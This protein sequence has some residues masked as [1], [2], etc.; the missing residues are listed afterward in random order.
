MT[1][2]KE[3]QIYDAQFWNA[4]GMANLRFATLGFVPV[5][6]EN[7]AAVAADA[8]VSMSRFISDTGLRG[9]VTSANSLS[10]ASGVAVGCALASGEI[11]S[12]GLSD[13]GTDN[14]SVSG[15]KG[16]RLASSESGSTVVTVGLFTGIS[17]KALLLRFIG[18]TGRLGN[19]AGAPAW[20]LPVTVVDK[21]AVSSTGDRF[22]SSG[23]AMD[24]PGDATTV[25]GLLLSPV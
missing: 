12:G 2:C 24:G 4:L 20:P 11:L 16:S 22:R 19:R 3:H 10:P 5:S 21:S 14:T 15:T 9:V 17:G 23:L 18:V 8:L 1:M 7:L 6:S 13:L 25:N